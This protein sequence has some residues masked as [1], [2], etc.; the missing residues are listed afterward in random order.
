MTRMPLSMDR[1]LHSPLR[2][3]IQLSHFL[4]GTRL[5]LDQYS[6]CS[7]ILYVGHEATTN[8]IFLKVTV[9]LSVHIEVE[10]ETVLPLGSYHQ[11]LVPVP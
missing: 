11:W 2:N 10:K 9:A 1:M 3:H 7:T 4:T 8:T 5:V 6:Q